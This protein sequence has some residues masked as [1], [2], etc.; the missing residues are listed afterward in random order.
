MKWV[1]LALA[2]LCAAPGASV[3]PSGTTYA[4]L[5]AEICLDAEESVLL[6]R[7]CVLSYTEVVLRPH[8]HGDV[9]R[10]PPGARLGL[11]GP[12]T[13]ALQWS[14]ESLGTLLGSLKRRE[15]RNR[16]VEARCDATTGGEKR[17]HVVLHDPNTHAHLVHLRALCNGRYRT[18]EYRPSSHLWPGSNAHV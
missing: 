15:P 10:E 2:V 7:D 11:P 12:F 1:P 17:G 13:G 14:R 18:T 8:P 5:V 3:G 9:S 4:P 16:F 6:R